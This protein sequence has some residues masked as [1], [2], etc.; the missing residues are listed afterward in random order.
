MSIIAITIANTHKIPEP[1][2]VIAKICNTLSSKWDYDSVHPPIIESVT[3]HFSFSQLDKTLLSKP[4]KDNKNT[5]KSEPISSE[6]SEIL[7]KFYDLFIEPKKTS[8]ISSSKMKMRYAS[9]KKFGKN[10]LD[11]LIEKVYK[12]KER[13]FILMTLERKDWNKNDELFM[14]NISDHKLQFILKKF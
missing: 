7:M 1:K 9:P 2:Y 8:E 3:K 14:K 11:Q 6:E 13:V 10:T 12:I 4:K 5:K